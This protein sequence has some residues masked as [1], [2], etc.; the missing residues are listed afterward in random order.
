MTVHL[1]P[2][3]FLIAYWEDIGLFV[4]IARPR[5]RKNRLSPCVLNT[6]GAGA[7]RMSGGSSSTEGTDILG[8]LRMYV[9]QGLALKTLYGG[10]IWFGGVGDSNGVVTGAGFHNHLQSSGEHNA[11]SANPRSASSANPYPTSLSWSSIVA[12]SFSWGRGRGGS[13]ALREGIGSSSQLGKGIDCGVGRGY[14]V[15]R[16]GFPCGSRRAGI[17]KSRLGYPALR[18]LWCLLCHLLA[19]IVSSVLLL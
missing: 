16:G 2:I 3:F 19:A 4:S 14:R 11:S 7:L 9:F 17:S 15:S 1:S 10:V 13:R 12:V 5:S 6:H 8:E 18:L